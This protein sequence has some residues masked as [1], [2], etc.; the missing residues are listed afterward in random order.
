[1]ENEKTSRR[2]AVIL[3]KHI[4]EGSV[5]YKSRVEWRKLFATD[6]DDL[7]DERWIAE[8]LLNELAEFINDISEDTM[9]LNVVTFDHRSANEEG[10]EKGNEDVRES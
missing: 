1:M 8:V 7:P 9:L 3:E 4:Y 2:K 5:M 6:H 10:Q